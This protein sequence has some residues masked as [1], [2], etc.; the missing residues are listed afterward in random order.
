MDPNS[1]GVTSS[2]ETRRQKGLERE[3]N[4]TQ[5]GDLTERRK[6]ILKIIV[7]EFVNSATPVSSEI[8]S[9]KF[10]SPLSSAEEKFIAGIEF[11]PVN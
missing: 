11:G 3:K 8:I 2:G 10:R 1:S 6:E 4:Q 9:H 7:Q 5:A